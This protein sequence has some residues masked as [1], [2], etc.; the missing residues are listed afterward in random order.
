MLSLLAGAGRLLAS[1]AGKKVADSASKKA[2]GTAGKKLSKD[3]FFNR[4]EKQESDN[5]KTGMARPSISPAK[6]LPPSDIKD[7]PKKVDLSKGGEEGGIKDTF[8]K[9]EF[10]Q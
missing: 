7:P 3:K 1:G 2:A 6:L 9:I 5:I 10:Y 4:E 8:N